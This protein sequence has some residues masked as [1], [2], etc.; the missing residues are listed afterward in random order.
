MDVYYVNDGRQLVPTDL[1]GQNAFY[2]TDSLHWVS[3]NGT[4]PYLYQIKLQANIY[5]TDPTSAKVSGDVVLKVISID[6]GGI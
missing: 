1:G 3:S 4:K 5:S 2:P 6:R